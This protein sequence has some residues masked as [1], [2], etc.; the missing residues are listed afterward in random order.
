MRKDVAVYNAWE[1]EDFTSLLDVYPDDQDFHF[2][3]AKGIQTWQGK[4]LLDGLSGTVAMTYHTRGIFVVHF[5]ITYL[6]ILKQLA[7]DEWRLKTW[8]LLRDG[9]PASNMII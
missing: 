1:D 3:Q 4:L 5:H 9:R 2:S 7:I 8:T 6:E